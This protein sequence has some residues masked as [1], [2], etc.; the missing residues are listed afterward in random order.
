MLNNTKYKSESGELQGIV[1][2]QLV[3]RLGDIDTTA[4]NA[5]DFN[6]VKREERSIRRER[7]RRSGGFAAGGWQ[8]TSW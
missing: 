6:Q 4:A 2:D 5:P 1:E 3:T 7:R 8:V